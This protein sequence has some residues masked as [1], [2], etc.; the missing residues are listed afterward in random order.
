MSRKPT[1]TKR[2]G[3]IRG[4]SAAFIAAKVPRVWLDRIDE[5]V[6]IQD[7]DRSKFL[8]RAIAAHAGINPE[9]N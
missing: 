2:R 7:T 4:E 9:L 6:R 5:L 8:R 3:I 1:K